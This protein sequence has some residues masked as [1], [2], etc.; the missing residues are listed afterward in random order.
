MRIFL[1]TTI[2]SALCK[3][4]QAQAGPTL[5]DP[6]WRVAPVAQWHVTALFIGERDERGLAIV[7]KAAAHIAQATPPISLLNGGLVTM[8]K[9]DPTMLWIRFQPE[10]ALTALHMA[11]AQATGTEPST[12]RP[13]W[14]HI[15]LARSRKAHTG[16]SNGV[17]LEHL[18][19]DR[20]SLFRSEPSTSGTLHTE[21]A[22]WPLTGTDPVDRERVA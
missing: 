7:Q 13:Y 22:F 14:P 4:I 18:V 21:L 6:V 9:E 15:T 19:L 16:V 2:P 3:V 1:G 5:N 17:V 12:Y 8:P 20:I 10:P 11:L